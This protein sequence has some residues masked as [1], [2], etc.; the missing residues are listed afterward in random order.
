[1]DVDS[2]RYLTSTMSSPAQFKFTK[3]GITRRVAFT[4]LPSWLEMAAK[5]E[6]LYSIPVEHVAVSYTDVDG[7]EVTLSSQEELEDY[8]R[9]DSE[10]MPFD[11]SLS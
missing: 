1:V 7:D 4:Q 3:D 8:Y 2:P 9:A 11:V 6:S 5:L 10:T